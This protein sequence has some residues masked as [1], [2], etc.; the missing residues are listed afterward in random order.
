MLADSDKRYSL[1]LEVLGTYDSGI[2]GASA[3]EIVSYDKKSQ[4]LFVTNDATNSLD[5][6]DI[7][8]PATPVKAFSIDLSSLGTGVNSVAVRHGIVAV[9]VEAK[10]IQLPGSVGFYDSNGNFLSSVKVGALPDML[11]FTPNGH[12][13]LVA[14]EGEPSD[15]YLVDPEG[16]IS[17]IR[18]RK[19]VKSMTQADVQTADFQRFNDTKLD[20]RIRIFGPGSTV[21]QDLEPEYIAVSRDSKTAWVTLQE[22]NAIAIVSSN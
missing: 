7:S 5:V 19:D 11:T 21:A 18:M 14:N 15:N 20:P 17:I 3:A 12:A 10:P 8:A 9:A 1:R 22:N 13:L 2:I 4:R 16:S 6:L